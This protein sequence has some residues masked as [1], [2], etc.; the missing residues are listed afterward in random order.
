M[1]A[2]VMKQISHKPKYSNNNDA[3]VRLSVLCTE[4]TT[5]PCQ[6]CTRVELLARVDIHSI[7]HIYICM[8]VCYKK[9]VCEGIEDDENT[10]HK[11]ATAHTCY[12][13]T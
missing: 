8:Y 7:Y 3:T 12:E 5:T 10:F 2:C 11:Q 1:Y 4:K 6:A 13:Y 9:Y